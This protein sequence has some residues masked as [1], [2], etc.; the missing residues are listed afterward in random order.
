MHPKLVAIVV[1]YNRKVLLQRCLNALLAQ[2]I[3]LDRI[4]VV[5]NASTDGTAEMLASPSYRDDLC[6]QCE[7]LDE[8][9]GGAGGFAEGMR[10]AHDWGADWMWIMDDDAAPTSDALEAL[11]PYARPGVIPVSTQVDRDGRLYGA[12]SRLFPGVKTIHLSDGFGTVESCFFAFVGPLISRECVERVGL[13]RSDFFIS[14][15]DA[16]YALRCR[17]L[18]FHIVI[19][20]TSRISHAHGGGAVKRRLLWRT[21]LR[22]AQPNWRCY[23]DTRNLIVLA[24]Q[25]SSYRVPKLFIAG[26]LL[27]RS[28]ADDCLFE[29]R[30]AA[31]RIYYRARGTLDAIA[32]RM[33]RC[34]SPRRAQ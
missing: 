27:W 8:N 12:Y 26:W 24:L 20:G 19:V 17:K 7:R 14:A 31:A 29:P 4:F 25:Y 10:R 5:D 1:T 28:V 33:G 6:I 3:P 34:V 2:S 18:K 21:Y 32:G 30:N 11:L 9:I 13:P 23:Y 15:D 16:E 22:A